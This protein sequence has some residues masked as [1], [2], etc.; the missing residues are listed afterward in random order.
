MP[1]TPTAAFRICSRCE[2]AQELTDANFYR[3]PG[4]DFES[5]CRDCGRERNRAARRA[6]AARGNTGNS[7]TD[8]RKF[9]VEIEFI[10]SRYTLQVALEE[11]GLPV[12]SEGYTHRVMNQWKIVTDGSVSRGYELV[13]PPLSGAE[14]LAALKLACEALDAVGARVNRSCGLHVHH[15]VND[16]N[17]RSFGRLF[18]IWSRNQHATDGLVTQSRRNNNWARPLTSNDVRTIESLPSLARTTISSYLGYV[19]RYKALNVAAFPR[20]GTVEVRQHQGTTNYEKIAAWIAFGQAIIAYAKS[21]A[22]VF[23]TANTSDWLDTLAG[24]GLAPTTVTY[25]KSRASSLTRTSRRA[26]A[27]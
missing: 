16:L 8:R 10:G 11:R 15:D 20:Y 9:G 5:W 13:S 12:N 23:A 6:R 17:L 3:P 2:R 14:G 26:I 19:N 18:R 21:D 25:L 4:R 24:H 7:P 27:A 22:E 1:A